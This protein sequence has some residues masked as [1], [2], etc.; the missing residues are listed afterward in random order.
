VQ[1][2][3]ARSKSTATDQIRKPSYK[4]QRSR[5]AQSRELAELPGRIE[6]LEAEQHRLTSQMAGPAFYQQES[7]EIS[8]S[9][10]RLKE[11]DEELRQ[12][13]ARWEELE[14]RD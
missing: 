4:E 7:D 9:A 11:L 3:A 13:Y 6:A 12:A 1:A 5:A 2:A 14:G 10:G 8:R